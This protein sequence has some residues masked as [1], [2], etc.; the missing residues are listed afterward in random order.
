MHATDAPSPAVSLSDHALG[1]LPL[2][3]YDRT[4]KLKPATGWLGRLSDQLTDWVE[5]LVARFS[6]HGDPPVYSN[7]HFPWV[8][9]VEADWQ[10]VRAE[11]DQVMQYRD[12]MP[13]FQDIVKE[14]G[15]IQSDNDWKTFFLR[16]VGM[17]CRENARRCPE[18]MKML[19]KIPGVTTAFFSILSPRKHIPSHRGPWAGVLR[20]HVGLLVPEPRDQ[21]R[22]RIANQ[23]CLWQEGRCL[24]FDD[25]WN[26]EVWNDT[27]GYRVVLFI[28]F[29]RP[30]KWPLNWINHALLNLAPLAPFL[31]EA[32]GKQKAWEKKMWG[33][34]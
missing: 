16:G 33:K 21:V 9:A 7:A 4:H 5:D 26:H 19:E 28:D 25:T 14:V 6:I 32:K 1:R 13:S 20:L 31:R 11:L 12:S 22:I 34:K 29:E 30:L 24:I 2:N 15:L 23:T 3:A 27:D 18:T 17:D 10:K 8:D